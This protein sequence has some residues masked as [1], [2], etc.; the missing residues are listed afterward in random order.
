M[1]KYSNMWRD[2]IPEGRIYRE[3]VQFTSNVFVW[4]H[5]N[6]RV[7]HYDPR[8]LPAL[9]EHPRYHGPLCLMALYLETVVD[10]YRDMARE[11]KAAYDRGQRFY[12]Q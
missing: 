2:V 3:G 6:C 8:H 4:E 12:Y 1:P 11:A 7:D 5:D 9:P 10:A